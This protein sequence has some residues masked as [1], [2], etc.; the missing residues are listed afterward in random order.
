MDLLLFCS[1]SSLDGHNH[2]LRR[3]SFPRLPVP[4]ARQS[5]PGAGQLKVRRPLVCLLLGACAALQR[6]KA[7]LRTSKQSDRQ[8]S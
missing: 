5:R 2:S 4:A 6:A 1:P 8:L 7:A 3:R